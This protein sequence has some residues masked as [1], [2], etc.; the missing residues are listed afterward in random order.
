MVVVVGCWWR[1]RWCVWAA[2]MV[3]LRLCSLALVYNF[4]M[5]FSEFL[6]ENW[7]WT[8]RLTDGRTHP[9]IESYRDAWISRHFIS[10]SMYFIKLTLIIHIVHPKVSISTEMGHFPWWLSLW[11]THR[12]AQKHK[13]SRPN[14]DGASRSVHQIAGEAY[15][16]DASNMC[17]IRSNSRKC[18]S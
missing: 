18:L 8:Y 13:R 12:N 7:L 1:S 14:E 17:Y 5:I 2:L 3:F 16:M 4:T 10:R 6:M 9:L 11:F 15:L